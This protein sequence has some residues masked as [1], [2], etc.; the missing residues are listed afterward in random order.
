[1][2]YATGIVELPFARAYRLKLIAPLFE[3]PSLYLKV[4]LV[5]YIIVRIAIA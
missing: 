2:L 5:R 3:H 1:M 4:V